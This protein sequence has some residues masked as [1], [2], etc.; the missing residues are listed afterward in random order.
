MTGR[1]AC[2]ILTRGGDTMLTSKD[3][4]AFFRDGWNR[5]DVERADDVQSNDCVFEST[6][7][8]EACGTRHRGTT[9]ARGFAP[10][11]QDISPTPRRRCAPLRRRQP[12]RS[13]WIFRGRRRRHEGRGQRC[14]VFTFAD[15][16]IA[17]KKLVLQETDGVTVAV[18]RSAVRRGRS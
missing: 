10:G 18:P 3:L 13:E 4:D 15:D 14:D 6:A 11:V 16:K 1:P 9:R 17:V 8:P 7:G 5:H 2:K 12:R